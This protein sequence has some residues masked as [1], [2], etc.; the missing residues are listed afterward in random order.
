MRLKTDFVYDIP[1][2]KKKKSTNIMLSI[3]KIYK[4]HASPSLDTG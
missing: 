3:V 4:S 2:M 1:M